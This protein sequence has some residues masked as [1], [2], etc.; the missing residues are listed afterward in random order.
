MKDYLANKKEQEILDKA[1]E[2]AITNKANYEGIK[3][4]IVREAARSLILDANTPNPKII[5]LLIKNLA[6]NKNDIIKTGISQILI[7]KVLQT[8]EFKKLKD[9]NHANR[10]LNKIG[11]SKVASYNN[12]T[13]YIHKHTYPLATGIVAEQIKKIRQE[14]PGLSNK[15]IRAELKTLQPIKDIKASVL[16]YVLPE[17]VPIY[18]QEKEAIVENTKVTSSGIPKY[19]LSTEEIGIEM[20]KRIKQYTPLLEWLSG[21]DEPGRTIFYNH[22]PKGK[23]NTLALEEKCREHIHNIVKIMLDRNL[24]TFLKYTDEITHLNRVF[25]EE[26]WT[27]KRLREKQRGLASI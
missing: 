27:E 20:L 3:S 24:D 15:E 1:R 7:Y 14:K 25:D 22:L 16:K 26:L 6:A 8:D 10:R 2:Q 17:L 5:G 18:R 11:K 23:S 9:E 4:G 12:I 13:S 21:M 19:V